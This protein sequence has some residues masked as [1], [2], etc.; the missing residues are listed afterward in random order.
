MPRGRKTRVS[1]KQREI[2]T[3]PR[4]RD[5]RC[6]AHAGSRGS[7]KKS[8]RDAQP[9]ASGERCGC[10]PVPAAGVGMLGHGGDELWEVS[11]VQDPIQIPYN[12]AGQRFWRAGDTE[13]SGAEISSSS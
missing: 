8:L 3:N 13:G 4:S 6:L 9:L 2:H 12:R 10:S 1:H 5:Q 7:V 11:T